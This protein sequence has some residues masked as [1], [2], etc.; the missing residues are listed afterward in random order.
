MSLLQ[1][2]DYMSIAGTILVGTALYIASNV[3]YNLFLHPLASFPGPLFYRASRLPWTIA[4]LRGRLVFDLADIHKKYGPVVRIAPNELA[5]QDPRAWRD[6]MGGGASEIPKWIGMYGVPTFLQPHI[7]NTISKEHHRALRRTLAPGFS[8]ASL[9]AQEPMIV[10]YVDLMMRRLKEKCK[11]GPLNLELWYRYVVFDIICDLAV[12]ESFKCLESDDLHPWITAMIEG[13]KPMGFLTAINM[14][15]ALAQLLNP[16]LSIAAKG[17]MRLHDEMVKPMVEKRLKVGD[18][19]DLINPLVRLQD[20]KKSSMSELIVNT[21]V[22]VGAGAETSAGTL[23]AATSLLIDNPDKFEKLKAEVRSAFQDESQITA[24]AVSRLPYLGACLDEA[25]RLFPQT[26]SPSLRLTDKDTI[27]AGTPVPKNTVVG[28]WPWALYRAPN[29][30]RDHEDFHPERFTG[31]P[32]YATDAREAFK[33]FFTGSRDCIGQNLALIEMRLIL[34]R[35]VF[36]FDIQPTND[37]HSQNWLS[38]QKNLYIVWDKTPLPVQ[39]TPVR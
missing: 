32:K 31:D 26:G 39:L 2:A 16:V 15:P 1:S 34:A 33:P 35:M 21:N 12:G 14:Y 23:T 11:E 3:L 4:L 36:N 19:P 20:G 17:P 6:V 13:G 30:W 27:I 25:L 29:L 10:Q 18:R 7:Q 24:S 5:F 22:I 37:P 8:D 38:Q 9:R 28:I